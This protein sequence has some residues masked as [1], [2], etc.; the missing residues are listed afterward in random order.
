MN[1]ILNETAGQLD[2]TETLAQLEAR[3]RRAYVG[4][5]TPEQY[6]AYREEM[7]ATARATLRGKPEQGEPVNARELTPSQYEA[8]KAAYLRNAR[9]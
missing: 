1:E 3:L 5:L 6:A 4:R 9:R 8:Q 2:A 7:L